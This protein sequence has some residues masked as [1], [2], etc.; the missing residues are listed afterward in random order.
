MTAAS[1]AGTS[2]EVALLHF[3]GAFQN[4]AMYLP[5]T[6]PPIA[7]GLLACAALQPR[8]KHRAAR[9]ALRLTA[10]LGLAGMAFHAYGVARA[11]GGWRN[12]RQTMVDGPPIPA[13]PSFTALA[14]AG[15]AALE[16]LERP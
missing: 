1:L 10:A 12:W 14:L 16:L 4:P 11:M 6:V 7:A 3:R 2:A 9:T 15:L 5:V 8:G 13:P